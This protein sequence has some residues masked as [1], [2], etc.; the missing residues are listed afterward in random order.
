MVAKAQPAPL[1]HAAGCDLE[2]VAGRPRR[3]TEEPDAAP[4]FAEP[5]AL[6]LKKLVEPTGERREILAK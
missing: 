5:Q 4:R 3:H 1:Q 2:P 6:V